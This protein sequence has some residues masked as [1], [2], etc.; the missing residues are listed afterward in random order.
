MDAF[1]SKEDQLRDKE[2]LVAQ[3]LAEKELDQ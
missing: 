2:E 1:R 3:L